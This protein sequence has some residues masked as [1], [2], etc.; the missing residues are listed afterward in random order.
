MNAL[1]IATSEPDSTFHRQ[2]VAIG[3]LWRRDGL[4]SAVTPIFTEGSVENA[5]LVA[6]GKAEFGCMAANWLPPAATGGKPFTAALPIRLLT[7]INSGPLF[8]AARADSGLE[9]FAD[10]KGR[11]VALGV[12]N[13][14]MVQHAEGMLRAI[15]LAP[16]FF[17]P[18]Y[19]G[20]SEGASMLAEGTIDAQFQPPIPNIHFSAL[21]AKTPVKVL[22][23][24]TAERAAIMAAVPSYAEATIPKNAF[25]GQ[26]QDATTVAV[27][28]ILAV[29]PDLDAECVR[30]ATAAIVRGA[31]GLAKDN[32]LFMGLGDLLRKSGDRLVQVLAKAGAAQ[33]PAAAKAFREAGI[34]R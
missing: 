7:P 33:H 19:A 6:A 24:S 3:E 28:N 27:V 22:P 34:L 5:K 30:R 14:G 13:S 11:R 25:P 4:A 32:P 10:L 1:R 15:G 21:T 17:E 8:F 12:K 16:G 31:D 29:H 18:V 2:A 20:A 26:R 9:A 23:F